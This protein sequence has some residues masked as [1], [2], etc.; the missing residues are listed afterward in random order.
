[1]NLSIVTFNMTSEEN[2]ILLSL[3]ITVGEDIY[4]HRYNMTDKFDFNNYINILKGV[5]FR[6]YFKNNR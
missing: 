5:L 6:Y 4:Y 3:F 2:F 1:M